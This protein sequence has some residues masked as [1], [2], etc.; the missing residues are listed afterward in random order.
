MRSCYACLTRY[1]LPAYSL[2]HP[3]SSPNLDLEVFSVA[4]N[5][6]LLSPVSNA[7][8]RLYLVFQLQTD[9]SSHQG[10]NFSTLVLI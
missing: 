2:F 8:C 3:S 10:I 6:K 7:I 1:D 9:F 5:G 4:S